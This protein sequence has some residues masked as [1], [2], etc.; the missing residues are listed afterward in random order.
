MHERPSG[1]RFLELFI[2][3]DSCPSKKLEEL[4]Q[5]KKVTCWT[6]E[7]FLILKFLIFLNLSNLIKFN[8]NIPSILRLQCI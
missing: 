2:L 6:K 8:L 1:R 4:Q 7:Q 3:P 5:K